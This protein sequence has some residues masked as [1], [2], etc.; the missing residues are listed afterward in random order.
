MTKVVLVIS[1]MDIGGAEKVFY[2]LAERLSLDTGYRVT[3]VC[4]YAQG[5]LG[6]SL[7]AK[8]VE[9]HENILKDKFDAAGIFR[10]ADMLRDKAPD[11][12]YIAGQAVTQAVC[13]IAGIFVKIPLKVIGFH[14]HNLVRRSWIKSLTDKLSISS[15]GYITCV[16]ESQK[17]HLVS[18]KRAQSEKIKVIYNGVDTKIFKP[19]AK[20][21]D[22]SIVIG[23]VGSMRMEKGFDILIKAI[24]WVLNKCPNAFFMMIGEGKEK[25]NLEKLASNLKVDSSVRF[26]GQREDI[27]EI[28]PAFDIACSSSRIENFPL[29]ILEYMAC[30][31]PVVAT[32]IGGVPEMVKD[33]FN[34][35]AVD[36]ESPEALA[37]AIV[38]LINDKELRKT[39]GI[40]ARKT[41][42]ENFTVEKMVQN[43]KDFFRDIQK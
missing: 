7:A 38:C 20:K 33:G 28:I 13:L 21:A 16:S 19:C 2:D 32:K 17:K 34:G 11:I 8:G 31:K 41:V 14:S 3:V 24:P 22:N 35:V 23:A 12:L 27:S 10:L 42:E 4:L 39:M 26:L 37:K 15:A 9:I 1:K 43:Y 6:D 36:A 18:D 40:N 5:R 30:A 29:S 25:N